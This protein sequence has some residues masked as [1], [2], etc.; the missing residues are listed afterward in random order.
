MTQISMSCPIC[1]SGSVHFHIEGSNEH[2]NQDSLGSSRV[3][4]SH[5]AILRCS[6]CGF[7]F[8]ASRLGE[9]QLADLYSE[10]DDRTYEA[11]AE[12]RART[13]LQHFKIVRHAVSSGKLLDVGCA[14]GGFLRLCAL[15]GF[16]VTGVE[17]A[18][19]LAEKARGALS[20]RGQIVC[21]TLQQA[22]LP[23]GSFDLLTLWDVLEHVPE[24]IAFLKL[25]RS[26]LKPEG[27][28]FANVPDLDSL[29]A[30]FLGSNWPLLLPEHFNYFTQKS[31][32]FSARQAG[33]EPLRTGRRPAFFSI[34]YIFHRLSQHHIPGAKLAHQI[35]NVAGLNR[36]IVPIL[37]GEIYAVWKRAKFIE[38]SL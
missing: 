17:P 4:V 36:L 15:N 28:L 12:G 25:C 18:R 31:L 33:F 24:P 8:L 13:A 9:A 37:L 27:Y 20:H 32:V 2:L 6:A 11:E 14:S 23:A 7:G 35:G 38:Y 29:Q 10:L 22:S 16:E 34:G 19:A 30:R 26:L 21:A 1:R 3:A 5:G